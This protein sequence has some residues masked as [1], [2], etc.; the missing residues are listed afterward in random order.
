MTGT[1]FNGDVFVAEA[2]DSTVARET[3]RVRDK[4]Q[5]V[6]LQRFAMVLFVV[7]LIGVFLWVVWHKNGKSQEGVS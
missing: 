1:L 4:P 3:T 6:T 5:P 7:L 2:I